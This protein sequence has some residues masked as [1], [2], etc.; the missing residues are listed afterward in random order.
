MN[1]QSPNSFTTDRLETERKPI[2]HD[3]PKHSPEWTNYEAACV[4]AR[5]VRGRAIHC[6]EHRASLEAWQRGERSWPWPDPTP[7]EQAGADAMVRGLI[8]GFE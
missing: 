2:G 5:E 7:A 4:A 6:P 1:A 8:R 3:A